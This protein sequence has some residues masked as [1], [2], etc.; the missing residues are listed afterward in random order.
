MNDDF[1]TFRLKRAKDRCEE[2]ITRACGAVP[3]GADVA[4]L[5]CR[6]AIEELEKV[7]DAA[8][9]VV[10]ANGLYLRLVRNRKPI[11]PDEDHILARAIMAAT[12]KRVPAK[13]ARAIH[14]CRMPDASEKALADALYGL[15][16][17]AEAAAAERARKGR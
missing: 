10:R 16:K 12:G 1:A 5:G 4:T 8:R 7:F 13:L 2:A 3:P 9:G 17:A 14:A 15:L 11:K 6:D